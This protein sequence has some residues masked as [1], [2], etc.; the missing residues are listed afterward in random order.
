MKCLS[1]FHFICLHQKEKVQLDQC[2]IL[3]ESCEAHVKKS[4]ISQ[5]KSPWKKVP[6]GLVHPCLQN[7]GRYFVRG[8]NILRVF[9]G[10][11]WLTFT[12]YLSCNNIILKNGLS[13]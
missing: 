3:P 1:S 5:I 10:W 7:Y 2:T 8:T 4:K 13:R 12:L 6:M 9:V 11:F